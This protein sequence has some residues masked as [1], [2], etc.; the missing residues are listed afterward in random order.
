MKIL[1]LGAS[2][3]T[4]KHLVEQL[5]QSGHQVKAVVRASAN[6][7]ETWIDNNKIT[8]IE[9]EVLKMSKSEMAQ[10]I[11]DCQAVA[12]CLGH[13]LS[14]KGIFGKP[15]RLVTDSVKL[16]CDSIVI[17]SPKEP[18]K[19]VLMNTTGNRNRGINEHITFLEKITMGLIRFLIPPQADNEEAADYLRVHVGEN[20]QN[21][22]W[23]I[24]RPDTLKNEEFVTKYSIHASPTRSAI[25]NPGKT[26]RI[27]VGNFMMRLIT[28]NELW[29]K[30]KGQMPV[31][32]N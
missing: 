16:M 22:E 8:I 28:E 21:I 10:H 9:S 5:V 32:Y 11:S 6:I 4:G 19:F 24:V 29:T 25:F 14:V 31:I 17:N 30:W 1:V 26:S 23:V 20:N 18:I 3:A 15:R 7:P 12:S 27:N 13:N 2:G